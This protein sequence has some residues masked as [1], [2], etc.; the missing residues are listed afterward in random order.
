MDIDGELWNEDQEEQR[1][2]TMRR[3]HEAASS[4]ECDYYAALNVSRKATTDDIRE[5]HRRLSRLFH[6]DRHHSTDKQEFARRQFHTIQRAYEVLTDPATR[7]AYDQLGEQGISMSKTVA[8][9]MYTLNDLQDK[10]EREA[11]LRRL[12]DVDEWVQSQSEL[13]LSVDGSQVVAPHL[14]P[15]VGQRLGGSTHGSGMLAL[16]KLFMSHSFTASLSDSVTGTIEGRMLSNPRKA[17]GASGAVK[18]MVKRTL[19]PQSW[20]SFTAPVLP[21]YVVAAEA[22]HCPSLGTFFQANVEQHALDMDIPPNITL[23]AGRPLTQRATAF[24]SI[25]TGNQY[26][27][28]SLWKSS[29]TRALRSPLAKHVVRA[30]RKPSSVSIGITGARSAEEEL[31]AN[32]TALSSQAYLQAW[33]KRKVDRY[34]SVAGGLVVLGYAPQPVPSADAAASTT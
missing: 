2:Q 25:A 6:P 29:P 22:V 8:Y 24:M 16:Q 4:G 30:P 3:E 20:V 26:T 33:Y 12:E 17:S 11:R 13:T 10:F 15:A 18:V 14:T 9:K 21:P 5:S 23:R 27:L 1:L 34:F 7:A 31:G 32:V 28:G 19:G